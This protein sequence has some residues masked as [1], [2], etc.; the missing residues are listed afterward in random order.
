MS[1]LPNYLRLLICSLLIG[2][3]GAMYAGSVLHDLGHTAA[4]FAHSEKHH[5]HPLAISSQSS[6]AH[7]EVTCFFC[8]HAPVISTDH[9]VEQI[10]TPASATLAPPL[11]LPG[12][13]H[14]VSIPLSELRG[15]PTA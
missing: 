2:G 13:I 8:T 10:W 4:A 5:D 15:P 6:D 14:F 11:D 3:Y 7:L 1:A 12:A 9:V